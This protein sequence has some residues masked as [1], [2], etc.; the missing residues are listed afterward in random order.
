M[1]VSQDGDSRR[2]E[3]TAESITR[4]VL[5]PV[6]TSLPLGFLAFGAGSILLTSLELGWVPLAQT[7]PLMILVLA[8]VAPLELLAGIFAF[9]ARD[10]GAATG[11][12]MLGTAWVGTGVTILTGPPGSTSVALA[13][14]LL[15][16]AAA[17]LVMF[18]GALRA[19]PL[20]GVLLA[21]AACRFALTGI[22]QTGASWA[23]VL[24]K[25]SGWIGLP[26]AVFSLYGGLALL[27]EDGARRT[28][29]P[30]ARRGE[31]RASLEGD[32]AGQIEQAEQE[33]GIR[34]QL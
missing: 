12:C 5:R 13:I 16:L 27:L 23:T 33:P 17:M 10:G 1:A 6:A 24:E 29:L 2:G 22:Y 14:F 26:L 4:I 25:V 18:A 31:A 11:L 32:L 34:R 8:F 15:F 20:F 7:R 9:L 30:L 3:L 28:V 19:K 21:A